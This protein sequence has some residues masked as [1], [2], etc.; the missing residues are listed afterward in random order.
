MTD[1][2]EQLMECM[3]LDRVPPQ[4]SKLAY[5]STRGL[6]SWLDNLKLRLE[7]INRWKEDPSEIPKVIFL[8]RLFNPQSFLTAIKQKYSQDN[9]APLNK[10]Y[11]KTDVTKKM[12]DQIEDRAKDGAYVFGFHIDGARWDVNLG[13][14]EES[15]PKKPYSVMPVIHCRA[16]LL[17]ENKKEDKSVFQ[18]P[19]Y[20]TDARSK[21]YV[22]TAQF[23]TKAPPHKWIL[24]GV[25]GILDV[26]GVADQANPEMK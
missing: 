14:L 1:L 8:N 10:L 21:T 18:C 13:Q 11:I 19:I 6:S 22:F 25:S 24:G 2:M 26:E 12:F 4:W 17:M 15:W 9:K 16:H 7:Q 20:A 3:F 23:R 5:P